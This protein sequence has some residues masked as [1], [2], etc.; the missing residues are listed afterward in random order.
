MKLVVIVILSGHY[1]TIAKPLG[2]EDEHKAGEKGENR[3]ETWDV[4]FHP[5][6]RMAGVDTNNGPY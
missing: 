3:P 2:K 1:S 5:C 6:V 4:Y